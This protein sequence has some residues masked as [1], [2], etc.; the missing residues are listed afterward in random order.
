[1][2]EFE[3]KISPSIDETIDDM[4]EEEILF[5]KNT[6]LRE[7][8]D[9]I[10]ANL[11]FEHNLEQINPPVPSD[12]RDVILK[13]IE[14]EFDYILDKYITST[15]G[16][17]K[18]LNPELI[19]YISSVIYEKINTLSL[20]SS[21]YENT[22]LLETIFSKINKVVERITINVNIIQESLEFDKNP[23]FKT[24]IASLLSCENEL[25]LLQ[26]QLQYRLNREI[27]IENISIENAVEQYRLYRSK[28]ERIGKWSKEREDI[29]SILEMYKNYFETRFENRKEKYSQGFAESTSPDINT[30]VSLFAFT[31]IESNERFHQNNIRSSKPEII[32]N[33]VKT[34]GVFAVISIPPDS[35]GSKNSDIVA[36]TL[37]SDKDLPISPLEIDRGLNILLSK[38]HTSA[39]ANQ[40]VDIS[41]IMFYG[42]EG[43]IYETPEASQ[44]QDTSLEDIFNFHFI[45]VSNRTN[46]F[47]STPNKVLA[48][49]RHTEVWN[50]PAKIAQLSNVYFN[51][52]KKEYCPLNPILFQLSVQQ[53][54]G[55]PLA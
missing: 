54:L 8:A 15:F 7:K 19:G 38:L 25:L 55:L 32:S 1:M 47:I 49:A 14:L 33:L 39:Q 35:I 45:R 52:D 37:K 26:E 22:Q 20:K 29:N 27:S 2:S 50:N 21:E 44:E 31:D 11:R 53:A 48:L 30:L 46:N 24:Y 40:D 16:G 18:G 36:L 9:E 42:K 51:N 5:D 41:D 28:L 34:P 4:P 6:P 17:E 12:I 23:I 43:K 3:P 10:I 13:D